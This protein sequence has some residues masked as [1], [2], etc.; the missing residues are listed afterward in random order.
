MF[1][2]NQA[3]LVRYK[4]PRSDKWSKPRIAIV[5]SYRASDNTLNVYVALYKR[6]STFSDWRI[7]ATDVLEVLDI[8]SRAAHS[9]MRDLP[10]PDLEDCPF[11]KMQAAYDAQYPQLAALRK[12]Y[13]PYESI[14]EG[15]ER[16]QRERAALAA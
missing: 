15:V 1:K 11:V 5:K 4:D 13:G 8:D 16:I 2:R 6:S 12:D 14:F 3:I 7:S 9:L 10:Q